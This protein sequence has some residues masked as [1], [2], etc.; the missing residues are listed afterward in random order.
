MSFACWLFTERQ[1]V[2]SCLLSASTQLI[3]VTELHLWAV[4]AVDA[5]ERIFNANIEQIIVMQSPRQTGAERQTLDKTAM[6]QAQRFWTL[7]HQEYWR[8]QTLGQP[9][10]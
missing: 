7:K 6:D 9:L 8:A 1:A 3:Q 4:C 5:F 2:E 10:G